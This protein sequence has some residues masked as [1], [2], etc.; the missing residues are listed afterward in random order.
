MTIT[1]AEKRK[2]IA[3]LMRFGFDRKKAKRLHTDIVK[4][5]GDIEA[6]KAK[7]FMQ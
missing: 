3:K 5:S 7:G 4:M 1:K 6:A 2:H